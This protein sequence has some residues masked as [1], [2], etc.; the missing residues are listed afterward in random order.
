ML[1][2]RSSGVKFDPFYG[3]ALFFTVAVVS[4]TGYRGGQ[5]SQG[6][7]HLTEH[8]PSPLRSL[9]GVAAPGN[10]ANAPSV[11]ANTVFA[12]TIQPLFN[13]HC[14]S[15]H[16]PSKHKAN[17]RLDSYE[18]VMRGSKDGPVIHP[19][20]PSK[21]ELFRRITLPATDDDFMPA[22]NKPPISPAGVQSI[23][24]W[25][26]A[27]ASVTQL[28]DTA[29]AASLGSPTSPKL[30]DVEFPHTDPEAVAKSRSALSA[31]VAQL[32]KQ[33]PNVLD[34]ESRGSANL[35]LNTS[36]L[37]A[38]FGDNELAAFAP[39]GDRIVTA[40]LSGTAISDHSSKTIAAMK[41]LRSL[42]LMRT[43]ISDATI[44]EIS[45]LPELETLSLYETPVTSASLNAFS[46]MPKLRRVYVQE[47]KIKPEALTSAELKSRLVF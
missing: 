3:A 2:S 34:Y 29:N 8:M 43:K 14:V 21:S 22:D 39:V 27:G 46:R 7:N 10:S 32:Q 30:P 11:A 44:E 24:K 28:A 5:L 16:G 38:K 12:A 6:E 18:A 42:R 47:T 41:H 25:I 20:E 17:L 36:L 9:F 35:I 45:G 4:F 37:G 26:T 31:T 1:R 23:E 15:C 13:D 33:F 19:G 40:D